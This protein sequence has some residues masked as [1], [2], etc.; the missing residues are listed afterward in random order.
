MGCIR[1]TA[2]VLVLC[3]VGVL[4][5]AGVALAAAPTITAISPNNGP[6]AGGTSVAITGTGFITGSTVKFGSAAAIG[7]TIHSAE[8]IT[9]TSPA[10]SGSELVNVTVT[11]SNGTSAPVPKDQF[12]YDPAPVSP[13]LGLNDD[14]ATY[15]GPVNLFSKQGIA[16]DRSFELVAGELPSELKGE[17][18]TEE[19][20][21]GLKNDYQYGMLPVSTIEYKGYDG[22][23]KS[24]PEFPQERTKEEEKE[25][26]NTIKGYVQG[27]LKSASAILKIV[28]EKY[29]GMQVL[30]EPMNE[31]WGYTTPRYNGTE[32]A[33]VIAQLL[34]EVKAAGI[35]LS[36]IYVGATGWDCTATECGEYCHVEHPKAECVSDDWVPTMYAAQ[37]K[38]E[39]E[40]QGWYFHPYGP[41]S[42]TTEGDS[43][44]IESLPPVQ[45]KM[46]SG[47]NNIIVS[48]VGYCDEEVDK[49]EECGGEGVNNAEAEKDMTE[50]LDHAKPYHEEGWLRALIVY[51]RNAH[52]YAM[53]EYPSKEITKQGIALDAFASV[54]GQTWSTQEPPNPKE[55]KS[56]SLAGISCTSSEACTAVGHYVNSSSIETPLAEVWASKKWAVQ[57][58]VSPTG[59]KSSSLSSVSCTTS[60]AC[61]A[62]GHYV[63]SSSVEVPL[64]EVWASKKWATQEA[65]TPTGAKSSS[66]AGVSCT[67][68]EACTAVGH[69]VNSSSVEVP[70]AE[71]WASKK[72]AIKEPKTPTGAKSSSLTGVSC[73]SSE[74]CIAVGHYV[75]SSSVEV[76]LAE[77]WTGSEWSIKEPKTPTGAKNSSLTGVSCTSSEACTGVGHYV[78][79]SSV[80]VTLAE[81]WNGKEWAIQTTLNPTEAKSSS[82]AGVSCIS[83]EACTAVSHYVSSA[84]VETTLAERWN[85]KEWTILTTATPKE[86][87]SSTLAGVSC[88]SGETCN[89]IGHYVNSSG[90]ESALTES[91][92]LHAPYAKTES[93]TSVTKT[94]AKLQGI[95]DPE[96]QET[97]YHFEYGPTTS[98]GTKTTEVNIGSS[99]SDLEESKV[100]TGLEPG[101]IY[102]F[103]IVA[104]NSIGTTTNGE[105]A[106][107]TTMTPAWKLETTPNPTGTFSS[108]YGVSCTS[109]TECTAVGSAKGAPRGLTSGTEGFAERLS[110]TTW[111]L[112]TTVSP[113]SSKATAFEGVTCVS[114]SSCE[115]V[116][117]Y[118][119][120][121]GSQLTLA[122]NWNGKEWA[123][124]ETP[125][126]TAGTAN[127]LQGVSCTS[128]TE[129]TA[130]GAY[131]NAGV[132]ETLAERWNGTAWTIQT[133]P[134]P[135]GALASVFGGVSCTSATAC[136]AA[137]A[138]LNSSD[139][140]LTLAESWN[141][142]TWTI[143]TTPNP[144][145][146]DS[147]FIRLSCSSSTACTAVGSEGGTNTLAERWNGTEWA[148]QKTVNPSEKDTRN[149]LLGVSCPTSTSCTAVGWHN[150]AEGLLAEHWNGTEWTVQAVP[151]PEKDLGDMLLGISCTS[152]ASCSGVG[153]S[154]PSG[155]GT[156][157]LAESY[158]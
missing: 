48:E 28:S 95:V 72:W 91:D 114:S 141:G 5:P 44:G 38:L 120:S 97:K 94:E 45:E 82:L 62:V 23:F 2:L 58:T 147:Q 6:D 51:S 37:P 128:A 102:H 86:A 92:M 109:A 52:G 136:I 108:L 61:T 133:T 53:Q 65:I 30:F 142:T 36:D 13:W 39:T 66:L 47:Q 22:A 125:N 57:E 105:D 87:K 149:L 154:N 34:P 43:Q 55:A 41:P 71:V 56:S 50:M 78:N 3:L 59:A 68:S 104:T 140:A 88:R 80:E 99:T 24:D 12:A 27:F 25:G 101:T 73:T 96:G 150:T 89:A 70:L 7:V 112:Q 144:N 137:G 29:P 77:K 106:T 40:I 110:G 21:T 90:T 76:P 84:S 75:N 46:N 33:N 64:V 146:K 113:A 63:N 4:A 18:R 152:I 17:G 124:Q 83:S 127:E 32:Y 123:I 130:V 93:A 8:S 155:G 119:N 139:Y 138:Y 16:Y 143:Q 148:V 100:I 121:S 115:A 157:T 131:N 60:E 134:N 156:V 49:G 14:S 132:Q 126:P 31:P 153:N 79:S 116:G 10:G 1:R 117:S 81:R 19:F 122:E 42:G 15:L 129:C 118:L 135:T 67:S 111:S 20:E 26:K 145:S 107:F 151:N 54:Y 85:G 69:Y 98:Y 158:L 74:A 9:A 103:R 11:N 35:P